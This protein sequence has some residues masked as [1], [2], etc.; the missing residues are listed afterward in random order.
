M[1]QELIMY[2]R[3]WGCPFA[4]LAKRVL[5]DY[6][7]PYREVFI[8]QDPAAHDRV[9]AWTGFLAVPTMVVAEPGE[10]LPYEEPSALPQ[11]DSPRGVNRGS[12]ITE[13]GVEQLIAW[14]RE[15][16]FVK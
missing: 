10:I 13:P 3:T 12:M 2:T 9:L 16:N 15:H 14:L 1:T 7:V 4:T 11:G 8:D 5:R 6:A